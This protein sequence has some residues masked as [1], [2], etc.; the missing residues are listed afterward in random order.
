[1]L[2]DSL[3]FNY[4]DFDDELA[5]AKGR[6]FLS[7]T[8]SLNQAIE[9]R[10]VTPQESRLVLLADGYLPSSFPET[11]PEDGFDDIDDSEM[12]NQVGMLGNPVPVSQGGQGE[13]RES[14]II[15]RSLVDTRSTLGEQVYNYLK[16]GTPVEMIWSAEEYKELYDSH[17]NI[18]ELML[19]LNTKVGEL[20]SLYI[21]DIVKKLL[22]VTSGLD[23]NQALEDNMWVDEIASILKG[24]FPIIENEILKDWEEK[25]KDYR[26]SIKDGDN[27]KEN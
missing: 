11:I 18:Q 7:I 20:S 9:K 13:V 8:T 14:Q 25:S 2:P 6:A 19:V 3:Y 22:D 16:E 17:D 15:Q 5:V 26:R 12:N 4:I 21:D 1:M 27:R 10:Y 23:I 24:E